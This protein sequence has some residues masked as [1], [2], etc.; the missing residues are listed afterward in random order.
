MQINLC[1]VEKDWIILFK[2][3]CFIFLFNDKGNKVCNQCFKK[4]SYGFSL[5]FKFKNP[6]FTYKTSQPYSNNIVSNVMTPWSR[7]QKYA[8][9]GS[10]FCFCFVGFIFFFVSLRIDLKQHAGKVCIWELEMPLVIEFVECR[11]ERVVVFQMK[12][13]H[14]GFRCSEATIFTHIHL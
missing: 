2:L 13:V 5:H 6:Y 11:T 12:V 9:I 10:L 14:F 3:Q 1:K 7:I 8:R 4:I